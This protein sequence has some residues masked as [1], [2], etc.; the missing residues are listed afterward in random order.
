M[1]EKKKKKNQHF[2]FSFSLHYPGWY[3]E[4]VT[5]QHIF[6]MNK[7]INACHHLVYKKLLIRDAII[8][9]NHK[10]NFL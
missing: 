6:W 7:F 4:K 3:S 9:H 2:S 1:A 10:E 8:P 5:S